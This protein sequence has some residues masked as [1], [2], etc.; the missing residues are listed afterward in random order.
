MKHLLMLI[1]LVVFTNTTAYPQNFSLKGELSGFERGTKIILN[2]YLDN[3]DIDRDDETILLL[4]DGKFEFSRQLD[5]P[6]KFSLRVRPQDMDRVEEYEQLTFW[7]ENLTMTLK[8]KKGQVFEASIQGSLIQD[9]YFQYVSEIAVLENISKQI[10]DSVKVL[11]DLKEDVKSKMRV[12]FQAARKEIPERRMNFIRNNPNY[13]CAPAEMVWILTFSPMEIDQ[14]QLTEFYARMEPEVQAN[15]YGRQI[16]NF[17]K[18]N[19]TTKAQR[20]EVGDYPYN[21]VLKDIS[22]TDVKFASLQAKV[23]LLDFWG[24]GCGPCRVEHKNY[25]SLYENFKNRGFEI[26]SV[27]M[28]QS[29]KLMLAAIAEDKMS[30]ICLWDESKRVSNE[31]YQIPW[32]PTNYVIVQGKVVGIDVK[33]EALRQMLEHYLND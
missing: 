7:A 21:F 13:Y 17:L 16:E 19:I 30:W 33:G 23:I 26:V 32:L 20:L 29:K 25:V 6:T 24:Y 2:P 27:S 31:L 12:R 22:G 5:K 11:P 10:I 1:V 28:D 9:Q 14:K 8:G 3:M 4:N 18:R 15:V